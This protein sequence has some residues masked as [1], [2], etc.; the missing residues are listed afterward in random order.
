MQV[1]MR[2]LERTGHRS[3]A[4]PDP[5]FPILVMRSRP[6]SLAGMANQAIRITLTAMGSEL[7]AQ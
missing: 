2:F 5:C 3:F 1:A 4:N 7:V 6:S